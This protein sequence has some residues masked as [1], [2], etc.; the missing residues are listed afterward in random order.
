MKQSLFMWLKENW[1]SVMGQSNLD[2]M[3]QKDENGLCRSVGRLSNANL[4]FDTKFPTSWQNDHYLME[5]IV[6]N[7]D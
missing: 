3:I 5:L 4:N 1:S 6:K 7:D 2:K